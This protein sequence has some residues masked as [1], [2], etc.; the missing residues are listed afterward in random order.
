MN[1]WTACFKRIQKKWDEDP[2]ALR[3]SALVRKW[4]L[5]V[6][7]GGFSSTE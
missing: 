3:L 2:W 7:K 1:A 5:R 6:S 4:N